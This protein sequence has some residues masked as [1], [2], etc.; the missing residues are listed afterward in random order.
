MALTT[1]TGQPKPMQQGEFTPS[2]PANYVKFNVSDVPPPSQ[3]YL[4]RDDTIAI[5]AVSDFASLV[6][7]VS[8]RLYL[9]STGDIKP[10]RQDFVMPGTTYTLA[11]FSINLAEGWLLSLSASTVSGVGVSRTFVKAFTA[12]GTITTADQRNVLQA[13]FA[14]YVRLNQSTGWPPGR[15]IGPMDSGSRILP[16]AIGSPAAGADIN[17]S[18]NALTRCR[19]ISFAFRLVTS[20]VAGNR[21]IAFVF[22]VGGVPLFG[23]TASVV[24]S[25]TTNFKLAQGITA[26]TDVNGNIQIPLPQGMLLPAASNISTIT[27]GK[28]AGDQWTVQQSSIEE[29]F[30]F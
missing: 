17:L 25:T 10:F 27:T 9:P 8:G 13:I 14:D 29:W 5:L 18:T 24:A 28:D 23:A 19:P 2:A 21:N 16:N 12:R 26:G 1:P 4:Q 7:T 6:L 20:A 3:F 30:D 15:I 11:T 22:G